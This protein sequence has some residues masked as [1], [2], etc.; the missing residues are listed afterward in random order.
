MA[1]FQQMVLDQ[2]AVH[3]GKKRNLHPTSH[4]TQKI[5]SVLETLCET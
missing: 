4:H 3:M 2:L 1:I 5:P